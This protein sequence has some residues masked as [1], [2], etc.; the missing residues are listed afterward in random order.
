MVVIY[1]FVFWACLLLPTLTTKVNSRTQNARTSC[2]QLRHELIQ[3]EVHSD[4]S[5]SQSRG[6]KIAFNL[7][8]T[9]GKTI[10]AAHIIKRH[11]LSVVLFS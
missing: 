5:I 8:A 2:R 1:L 3:K 7:N 9:L 4:N 6:G 11:I 10:R